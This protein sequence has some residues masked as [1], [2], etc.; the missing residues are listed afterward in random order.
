VKERLPPFF[1]GLLAASA[2]LGPLSM[3]IFL[4][5]LPAIQESF[6]VSPGTAQMTLSVSM[7]AIALSTLAYGPLSDR[8]GRRPVMLVGLLI[9]VAGTLIC[10]LAPTIWVLIAGRIVQAAGGAVGMVLSRAIVRDIYGPAE[11]AKVIATL[12]MVMVSAPM[13]APAIGGVLQDLFDWRSTFVFAGIV[14]LI[15]FALI[16]RDL[17]ETNR[18]QIPFA[19]VADMVRGF[20]RLFKSPAYCGY[21]FHGAFSSMVFFSFISAAPYVMVNVMGRPPTEYGLY[22]ILVTFGFMCGNFVTSRL[23]VQLGINRLI[24]IG[25]LTAVVGLVIAFG[26]VLQGIL[27]PITLFL[28]V[29]ITI[30]GNGMAMPNTQAGAINVFPQ[31]AGTASGLSGFLQMAVAAAAS[32]TVAIFH[33]GTAFPMLYFMAAGVILSILAI[34]LGFR[35]GSPR[36]LA[37]ISP[38]E[39][40]TAH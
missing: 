25:S 19:G 11:A 35:F 30:F 27:T 9:F 26:F 32:Q 13:V 24:V 21:A 17:E 12:T 16:I 10:I 31:M 4:P 3:Q 15:V 2:A 8:Y 20:G 23:S 37:A 22:F 38:E 29:M 1:V 7:I 34:T 18:S 39:S 28:P 36:E 40:V 33:D 14:S 5:S 6:A